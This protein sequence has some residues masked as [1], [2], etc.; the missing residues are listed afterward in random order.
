MA[1]QSLFSD[2]LVIDCASFIAGPAAGTI[3]AD[4][5]ARV[6]KIEPPGS[7]DGYRRLRQ[8]P[9]VP[10][11]DLNYPWR[12]TNRGKQSLSV[13]LK[14]PGLGGVAGGEGHRGVQTGRGR[15]RTD[16]EEPQGSDG[17]RGRDHDRDDHLQRAL[18]AASPAAGGGGDRVEGPGP[19][20]VR[21]AGVELGGAGGAEQP[22]GG[23]RAPADRADD[24]VGPRGRGRGRRPHRRRGDGGTGSDLHRR[25]PA[26]AV[27][28]RS[29]P[30][31]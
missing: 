29:V 1:E 30:A 31:G 6:I 28:L 26:G 3:L 9:G 4:F 23:V 14:Q 10:T 12:L 15:E 5:G 27:R 2:L 16:A 25:P 21:S 24:D 8:L 18:A 13:D 22:V 7:G 17:E 19:D 11:C 20:R